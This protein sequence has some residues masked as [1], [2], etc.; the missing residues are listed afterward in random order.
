MPATE[1]ISTKKELKKYQAHH[2]IRTLVAYEKAEELDARIKE[3]RGS[4]QYMRHY[5]DHLTSMV[6][7]LPDVERESYQKRVNQYRINGSPPE[8]Q[9]R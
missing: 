2:T 7:A 4:N 9:K 8:L 1:E 5:H 3:P 6:E